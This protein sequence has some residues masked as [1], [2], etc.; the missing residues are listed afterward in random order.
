MCAPR[1]P[2]P[3][4]AGQRQTS[5]WFAPLPHQTRPRAVEQPAAN[6]GS[7][8]PPWAVRRL[9]AECTPPGRRA[10]ET[11]LLRLDVRDNGL[12]V[13]ESTYLRASC[14]HAIRRGA[15]LVLSQVTPELARDLVDRVRESHLALAGFFHRTYRLLHDSTGTL[16]VACRQQ[17]A[18]SAE[19]IDSCPVLIASARSV[20]FFYRRHIVVAH[21]TAR[22]TELEPTDDTPVDEPAA[23][24]RRHRTIHTD[25]LVF[26]PRLSTT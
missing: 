20:G 9:R 1:V 11:P 26:T 13:R 14:D 3:R 6:A 10:T 16:V 2:R 23:N 5:V 12:G 15:P 4:S 21:T 22:P 8:L 19:L 24:A 25:L 7:L 18:A 17:H